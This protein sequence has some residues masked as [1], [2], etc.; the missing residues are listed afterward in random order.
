LPLSF[1]RRY[2]FN[3]L[4][5]LSTHPSRAALDAIARGLLKADH[6]A[7]HAQKA[8]AVVQAAPKDALDDARSAAAVGTLRAR[9][10]GRA[11]PRVGE[12]FVHNAATWQPV[13]P[14]T[15][16][17]KITDPKTAVETAARVASE[18]SLEVM[19][20]VMYRETL[21]ASVYTLCPAG[22]N[23]ET[24]RLFEAAEAGSIPIVEVAPFGGG[25][26]RANNRD[27]ASEA[28]KKSGCH[29]PWR[30]FRASGAPFVWLESWA[31]LPATLAALRADPEAVQQQQRAVVEWYRAYMASGV[32]AVA[33]V[34]AQHLETHD[35]S[36][37]ATQSH[38]DSGRNGSQSSSG[39]SRDSDSSVSS[40]SHRSRSSSSSSGEAQHAK[41]R[42]E[43]Q[44]WRRRRPRDCER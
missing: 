21:L 32:A 13:L 40:S 17:E 44:V 27:R 12:G 3:M 28:D 35:R 24:F 25:R 36:M 22:H 43:G 30:P 10:T 20:V 18:V 4:A 19:P 1:D 6:A 41:A 38:R 7:A 11:L 8:A 33:R 37:A 2:L 42:N 39:S 9:E 29:D 16:A 15:A 26:G 5:S 23:P 14:G 34:V 31:E